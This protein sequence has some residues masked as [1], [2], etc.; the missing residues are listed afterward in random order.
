MS[1]IKEVDV[2]ALRDNLRDLDYLS[3]KL[4]NDIV[5]KN[6]ILESG[7]KKCVTC[8]SYINNNNNNHIQKKQSHPKSMY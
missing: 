5:D 7:L 3:K 8:R 4:L 6:N 1:T 2:M